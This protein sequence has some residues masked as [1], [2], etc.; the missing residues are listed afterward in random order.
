[1]RWLQ[2]SAALDLGA[3]FRWVPTECLLRARST[4]ASRTRLRRALDDYNIDMRQYAQLTVTH[5]SR[6]VTDGGEWT[7]T[8]YGPDSTTESK[9]K[10]Y[11]DVLVELNRAGKE[12]W[13]LIGCSGLGCRW[14]RSY[15]VQKRLVVDQVHFRALAPASEKLPSGALE[16]SWNTAGS[17]AV[18]A[19][20]RN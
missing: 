17:D 18:V 14:Q 7:M 1:M 2:E 9:T 19:D 5:D 13:E 4:P 11:A 3:S 16:G 6:P 12:G 10:S 8:W 20:H 15:F